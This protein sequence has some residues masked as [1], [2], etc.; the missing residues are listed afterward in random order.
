MVALSD[1]LDVEE[2]KAA[3]T[4]GFVR[5]QVHPLLPLSIYNYTEKCTFE[6][7]WTDVTRKCRGLI[8]NHDTG[9]LVARPYEKFWNVAEHES[10][11][12]PDIPW[13]QSYRVFD[14]RDGSLG[15]IHPIG[16]GRYAVATRG[17]F[18]S[19][20]ALHATQLWDTEY[21]SSVEMENA[22]FQ[23]MTVVV[24]VIYPSN[25]I[26]VDHGDEDSLVLLGG[27]D[28][29]TG[30]YYTPTYVSNTIFWPGPV[31]E[32]YPTKSFD[33]LAAEERPNKEGYVLWFPESNFRVKVKHQEYLDLHRIVTGT[34]TRTIWRAL[35]DGT[36][37]E[38][39]SHLPEEFRD[40]IAA[41]S[42]KL[43]EQYSTIWC[44]ANQTYNSVKDMPTRKDQALWLTANVERVIAGAV[45]KMLDD[46]DPAPL[47]WRSIEPEHSKPFWGQSEA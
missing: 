44:I 5:K 26:V 30:Q 45:F 22:A 23:Q 33:E 15:V 21:A 29:L 14:K 36:E 37:I 11:S 25:R 27:I 2:L 35:M 38:T 28:N 17:S 16:E 9:E 32:E 8:V 1:I 42:Y 12:L 41:E 39:L 34:N 18:T 7:A 19:E 24:E 40:W 47:I 4:A 20:Q 3:V 13:D 31:V 46:Q 6:K 43:R 10:P